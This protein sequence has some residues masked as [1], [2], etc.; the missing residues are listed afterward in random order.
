VASAQ[1]K[2]CIL[3]AGLFAEGET[4][5]TEPAASRDHTER[6]LA[7]LGVPIRREGA[8]ILMD[9]PGP[10]GPK[11]S[12]RRWRV[13]GDISS[14]AFW[15]VAAACREGSD[16][17]V[18]D[19]GLNP[20]RSAFLDVLERMGAGID[21]A[22]CR[23]PIADSAEADWEPRGSITVRGT[24]LKGA[25][26]G[27]DEIPRMIDE[28][29]LIAAAGAM[30]G[31]KTVIR[32]AAELRVKETDRISAMADCLAALGVNVE[33]APDGLTVAGP[34]A[35]RGGCD[36]DSRGDHRIAMAASVLALFAD[37]P[38]RILDTA[39]VDTSYP[40]FWEDLGLVS[41]GGQGS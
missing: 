40:G 3:L 4:V 18:H 32:D 29:P 25:E 17:T 38:V 27:G 9:G 14:A 23:S 33:T 28:L 12:A 31:G 13:P 11:L 6:M 8:R 34:A 21:I 41:A 35:I 30:A 10:Q 22:D 1:I 26:V 15:I 20:T 16:L 37:A 7:A 39:C 5:V 36:V 24:V 2:S 19:V